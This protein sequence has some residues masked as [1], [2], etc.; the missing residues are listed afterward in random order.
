MAQQHT[1]LNA[2][3]APKVIPRPKLVKRPHPQAEE[4][5]DRFKAE[6]QRALANAVSGLDSREAQKPNQI[7]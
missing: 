5:A 7:D 2:S 6:E 3:G 1:G 4:I